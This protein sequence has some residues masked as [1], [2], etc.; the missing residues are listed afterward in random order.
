MSIFNPIR[1]QFIK[2][3]DDAKNQIVYKWPDNN[4]RMHT[5][6]TVE[7]DEVALFVKEGNVVGTLNEGVHTLDGANVPFI[8]GLLSAATGGDYFASELYFVSTKEFVDQRF[9]GT[10]DNVL[11]PRSGLAVGLR[12]FG[13]YAIK[14]ANAQNLI[15]NLIGTTNDYSMSGI[16]EWTS[17]QLLK[18]VREIVV[19]HVVSTDTTKTWD[20]LGIAAQNDAVESE[21]LPKVN[22]NLESY[23]IMITRL[24]NITISIN[25][26]DAATLKQLKRDT[27]YGSNMNA[28]DAA[29]KLGAAK[30]FEEGSSSPGLFAAGIGLG[31]AAS[32][33]AVQSTLQNTCKS[34]GAVLPIGAVYC[35]NCGTKV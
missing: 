24:A 16:S 1:K 35:M 2:R 6:L 18:V 7:P 30:G 23:G 34:C 5:Q 22:E 33:S 9:G 14:M 8:G 31:S 27:V 26:D 4:I 25:D 12:C 15:L 17:G 32:N 20:I 28:A 10:I 21:T 13:E 3:P 29:L 11:D 19:S